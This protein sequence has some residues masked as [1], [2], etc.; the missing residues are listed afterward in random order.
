MYYGTVCHFSCN[1]GFIGSGSQEDANAMELG[2][3]RTLVVKVS[4][5]RSVSNS[6][7]YV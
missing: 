2:L 5:Q 7:N 6:E 3:D 1:D 4:F